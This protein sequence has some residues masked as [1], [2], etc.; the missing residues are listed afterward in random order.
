MIRLVTFS[1]KTHFLLFVVT[2]GGEPFLIQQFPFLVSAIKEGVDQRKE[3]FHVPI[4]L[5]RN[6][7][8]SVLCQFLL[9]AQTVYF[10]FFNSLFQNHKTNK[11]TKNVF[12]KLSLL[13]EASSSGWKTTSVSHPKLFFLNIW[14]YQ[15]SSWASWPP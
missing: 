10:Q 4:L 15:L 3:K 6:F 2:E 5:A 12:S 7:T 13:V 1:S 14:F 8:F 9:D 11:Q